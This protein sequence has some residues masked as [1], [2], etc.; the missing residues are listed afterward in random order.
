MTILWIA[1]YFIIPAVILFL[2]KRF[3]VLEKIG[4]IIL[5]YAVGII[6]GNIGVLPHAES[7][8]EVQDLL[9]TVMI[10]L[11]LPLIFFSFDLRQAKRLARPAALAL[12]GGLISIVIAS[13][14]GYFLFRGKM[15]EET[16]MY[17][18]MIIG[19]YSGGT[20]N[21]GAIKTGLGASDSAYIALNAADIVI[22]TLLIFF[23]MTGMKPLFSKFLK[24]FTAESRS[25]IDNG[26]AEYHGYFTHF[27]F[28]EHFGPLAAAFLIALLI[29]GAGAS[30]TLVLEGA[31]GMALAI[32]A[33]TTLS[34]ATVPFTR[35]Y[36]IPSGF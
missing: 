33:I 13:M 19:V 26:E 22:S 34:L 5:T 25:D 23:I 14:L 7:F 32:L 17:S 31:I 21:L 36:W 27:R 35:T 18:G 2:T 8:A 1:L 15:G 11:A 4:I 6:L 30:I 24:P 10:V 3:P 9:S 28:K 16:W 29:A 20:P 12:T